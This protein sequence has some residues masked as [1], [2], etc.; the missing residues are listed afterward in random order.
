MSNKII[1]TLHPEN[2]DN[3]DL[4]P[5]IIKENIPGSSVDYDKL[6]ED[7]KALLQSTTEL[8]PSGVD[9]STNILAF[10]T[11]KGIYVG[12]DDGKWYYWDGSHYVL[13]GDFISSPIDFNNL[14]QNK[15]INYRGNLFNFKNCIINKFISIDSNNKLIYVDNTNYVCY[16][17]EINDYT[18]TYIMNYKDYAV[19]CFDKDFNYVGEAYPTINVAFDVPSGTKYISISITKAHAIDFMLV[20]GTTLPLNYALYG[21]DLKRN[22]DEIYE[23]GKRS[24]T[25]Q[26]EFKYDNLTSLLRQLKDNSNPKIIYIYGGT[27]DIY[28]EYGGYDYF[29]T[30]TGN[31][32]WRDVNVIVPPNTKIIGVGNVII[33]FKPS[34]T[35]II[36]ENIAHLFSA[37]NTSYNVEIE[38]ITIDCMNCRYCIHDEVID[39]ELSNGS[40]HKYKNVIMKKTQDT[41]GD[42]QCF[43]CGF[44]YNMKYEFNNCVF[45]SWSIPFSMHNTDTTNVDD[46]TLININNCYFQSTISSVSI[47]FRNSSTIQTQHKVNINNSFVGGQWE[48]LELTDTGNTSN[49]NCFDVTMLNCNAIRTV[50]HLTQPNIYPIHQYNSIGSIE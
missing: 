5:N 42:V 4:F 1:T 43:G 24:Y 41:Y 14:I 10:T 8:H 27:Y 12:S 46:G 48:N 26:K 38:N 33:K 21:S 39:L 9:T 30:L 47:S 16:L 19:F 37:L 31:E 23:V 17:A 18:S 35:Q 28:D 6:D 2:D 40:T 50:E 29:S 36:S 25:N 15:Y 49:V 11:N 13:G 20:E 3:I 34:S 7:V 32:D 22:C 44:G 45:T